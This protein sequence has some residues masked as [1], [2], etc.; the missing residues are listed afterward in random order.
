MNPAGKLLIVCAFGTLTLA[1][2]LNPQPLPP[3]TPYDAGG[4]GAASPSDGS[5]GDAAFRGAD[6][7]SGE[8]KTDGDATGPATGDGAAGADAAHEGGAPSVDSGLD[9]STDSALDGA[10]D[11]APDGPAANDA[12]DSSAS[13]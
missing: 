5:R 10:L 8:G 4:L 12:S 11:A 1:C 13:G 6:A 3:D 7:G 9:A 2:S